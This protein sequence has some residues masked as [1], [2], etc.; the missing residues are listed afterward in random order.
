[1]RCHG[2]GGDLKTNVRVMCGSLYPLPPGSISPILGLHL[3]SISL[4]HLA[5]LDV[6][7]ESEI[8]TS[9]LHSQALYRLS[10]FPSPGELFLISY[11]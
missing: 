2:G 10:H 9:R 11:Y 8:S 7:G 4:A 6:Y 5:F 1:M 3:A